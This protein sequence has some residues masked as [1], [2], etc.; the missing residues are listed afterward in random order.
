VAGVSWWEAHEAGEPVLGGW[1]CLSVNGKLLWLRC[2]KL[3]YR[4]PPPWL[5]ST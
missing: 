1:V 5:G 2:L 4:V 3:Y